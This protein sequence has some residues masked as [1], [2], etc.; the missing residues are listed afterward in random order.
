MSYYNILNLKEEPFSTS[1][2]PSFLYRS[3]GHNIVLNKL[4]INIRLRR[5]LSLVLG[6][7]GTGKTTLSR[8]LL[9]NF[10]DE[11]DFIF[12]LVLAPSYR[13]ER[14]FLMHLC[15]VFG[16]NI[17]GNSVMDYKDAL[18]RYLYHKG[19][20]ENKTIC[21]IIDEGQALTKPLV[22]V[23]RV[24]LNYETNEYKLLQ[25][26]IMAQMEILPKITRL[27][28]FMDRV[29][30]KYTLTPLSI[31]ETK[32]MINYRLS[33]AGY[34]STKPLFT[35]E[36]IGR[37]HMYTGGYPRKITALCHNTIEYLVMMDKREADENIID[38]IVDRENS[39]F[40]SNMIENENFTYSGSTLRR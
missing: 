13:T 27:R 4:E 28:N 24:L 21:L 40:P 8:A 10:K 31:E 26:I 39:V 11:S 29:A 3:K 20:D 17:N 36:A 1:P 35:D 6:D 9:R 12:H 33:H 38:E 2:D 25:L 16:L 14:Q 37:I 34:N 18:E 7:V 30:F 32:N 22:E 19:V 5:G 23:L 15:K